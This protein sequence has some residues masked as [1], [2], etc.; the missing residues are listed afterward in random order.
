MPQQEHAGWVGTTFGVGLVIV[1]VNVL[2]NVWFVT[3]FISLDIKWLGGPSAWI[4]TSI[5]VDLRA[6]L[7][8]RLSW[9]H[10][11]LREADHDNY[12]EGVQMLE[13]L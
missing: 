11:R 5:L 2:E 9:W 8:L 12:M 6:G 10:L 3:G 4:L 1:F 7:V 13:V